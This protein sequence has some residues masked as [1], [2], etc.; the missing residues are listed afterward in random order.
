MLLIKGLN[1]DAFSNIATEEYLLKEK[2]E[3]IFILWQNEPAIIVGKHQNALAEINVPFVMANKIPVVRRLTGG[4]T[5]FHDKGNINFTFI[6]N[7]DDAGKMIDFRKYAGPI[8]EGLQSLGLQAEFSPRND[9]FIDNKKIS[10]NA[11][12]I[13]AKKKRVLH[14]G[15]LLFDSDLNFLNEAIRSNPER[16]IDKAVNSVR[17]TV[18][19][20]IDYIEPQITCASFFEYLFNFVSERQIDAQLYTLNGVDIKAIEKLTAEKYSQWDWNFGYSPSYRLD[21]KIQI[22]GELFEL[23]LTIE[24]GIIS[25]VESDWEPLKNALGYRHKPDQLRI[26]LQENV[27]EIES[28]I[29][30]LF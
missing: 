13:Y 7:A 17:S 8:L 20:I 28:L 3:E 10:G 27:V 6:K 9:I 12:H 1:F 19:N 5:V 23:Q 21:K 4:G 26:L 22:E 15:T 30:Q 2:N 16:F 14:H 29:W 24:K 18:T 11:E 25:A